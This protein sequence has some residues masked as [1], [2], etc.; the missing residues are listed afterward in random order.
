MLQHLKQTCRQFQGFETVLLCFRL[1]PEPDDRRRLP[2]TPS[3]SSSVEQSDKPS[4]ELAQVLNRRSEIV[5][6]QQEDGAVVERSRI[7][8]GR[9]ERAQDFSAAREEE[10]IADQEVLQM[11]KNRRKETDSSVTVKE[12]ES[13]K[14]TLDK[15]LNNSDKNNSS[16][17]MERVSQVIQSGGG[18]VNSDKTAIQ[19]Q[20][21]PKLDLSSI[22]T[23]LSVLK[24]V[25]DDLQLSDES[26]AVSQTKGSNRITSELSHIN[27]TS[28]T[29]VVQF[30][31]SVE[32]DKSKDIATD[33]VK[34]SHSSSIQLRSSVSSKSSQEE[35][36]Q[37][38]SSSELESENRMASSSHTGAIDINS[39]SEIKKKIS[40]RDRTPER[41]TPKRTGP[42]KVTA[43]LSTSGS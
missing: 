6:K 27:V 7:H 10:I 2:A 21:V 30:I 39:K 1:T 34:K 38:T 40:T 22:D 8:D 14:L 3:S 18:V 4:P 19:K 15:N 31:K 24:T 23:S 37:R 43:Q 29:Q 16:K 33:D 5:A 20:T 9:V 11:L 35:T 13:V 25:T 17:L 41:Q 28:P 26:M 32:K 36:I 12:S 42:M